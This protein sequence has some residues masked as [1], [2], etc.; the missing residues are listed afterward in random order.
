[1]SIAYQLMFLLFVWLIYILQTIPFFH[2]ETMNM[3]N[4]YIR[5]NA[6]KLGHPIIKYVL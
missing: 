1:V 2:Y 5:L 3:L 4:T 6:V